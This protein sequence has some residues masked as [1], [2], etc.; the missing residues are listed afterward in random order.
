M[1]TRGTMT[2]D[3]WLSTP[4]GGLKAGPPVDPAHEQDCVAIQWAVSQDSVA[5][6]EIR[7]WLPGML[8]FTADATHLALR[9]PSWL[10]TERLD[11]ASILEVVPTEAA[12]IRIRTRLEDGGEQQD[13]FVIDG[14]FTPPDELTAVRDRV[15]E[16]LAGTTSGL[17]PQCGGAVEAGHPFCRH[18]GAPQRVA[19]PDCDAT[20]QAGDR[21]CAQCG[22]RS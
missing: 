16:R 3:Q 20:M 6:A 22:H 5:V 2:W 7:R 9:F 17:C 18:C 8:V 11:T 12:G 21:F 4:D 19:C 15:V 14:R 13:L 10:E 1:I